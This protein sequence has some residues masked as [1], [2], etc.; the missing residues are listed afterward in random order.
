MKKQNKK[1]KINNL[2][3]GSEGFVGVALCEYLEKKGESVTHFDIKRTK[4]E[5][6]RT[7]VLP[8]QEF[9]RVYFLAWEVGGAKY[10]YRDNTQLHQLNWNVDL[11]KN[12]M[13]QLQKHQTP[14]IFV[15]SQLAEETD[16]V[17]GSTKK[18]GELW[19][20]Q[21]GGMCVRLWNVYGALEEP[22]EK[23]HVVGDFVHQ[24]LTNGKIK[25]ISTG[26]EKRQFIHIQDVCDGLHY[27]LENNLNDAVYDITSFEWSTVRHIADIVGLHTKAKV[28]PGAQKG[29][30]RIA[31]VVKGKPP[32]WSAKINLAEGIKMMVEKAILSKNKKIKQ[33][34]K[35][36]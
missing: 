36:A 26:E 15:S 11:L 30:T 1:D 13:P 23:S 33:T 7:A 32:G 27:V 25:M 18:L 8:L 16:T 10:L 35:H 21:I 3:I 19:T 6:G 2:V 34:K 12:I 14:F 9:D 17:Y 31:A 22:T 29:S 24:A 4:K 20:K 28:I 5:D